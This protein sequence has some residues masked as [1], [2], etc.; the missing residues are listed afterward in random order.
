[1]SAPRARPGLAVAVVLAL[2]WVGC[3]SE[4]PAPEPAA[5]PAPARRATIETTGGAAEAA[6][7]KRRPGE[8]LFRFEKADLARVVLPE[9]ERQAQVKV[10]WDGEPREV[11]LRLHQPMPW[12]QALEL[13]C[14]WTKTHV[15]KDYQGRLVLKPGYGGT[16]DDGAQ[17]GSGQ[18]GGR[19]TGRASSGA[20]GSS[21]GA[22]TSAG[23]SGAAPAGDRGIPQPTGA[24][25]GGD[26]AGRLLRGTTTTRSGQ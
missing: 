16:L 21:G 25:S 8:V 26:E 3:A 2:G 6:P 22:A 9:F 15:T 4:E 12:R 20:R 17:A 10:L 14:Q 24:Y 23:A 1:M 11:T 13:V 19:S 7:A 18:Q 5:A